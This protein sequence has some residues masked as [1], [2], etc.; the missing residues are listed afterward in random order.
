MCR[1]QGF[2]LPL[3]SLLM[4]SLKYKCTVTC[5]SLL[6]CRFAPTVST[7]VREPGQPAYQQGWVTEVVVIGRLHTTL[8][9][10]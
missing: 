10:G 6:Y 1:L 2:L 3:A 5:C 4:G 8:H 9:S 7:R